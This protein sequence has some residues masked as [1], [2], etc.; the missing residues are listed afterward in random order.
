M[1]GTVTNAAGA[2]ARLGP[3]NM[4][5]LETLMLRA[6]EVVSRREL[7]ETVWRNQLISEDAL[8][9]CISDIRAELRTFSGHDEWI[10]T[11]PKRGYR[12]LAEVRELNPAEQLAYRPDDDAA[13]GPGTKRSASRWRQ[14]LVG[15]ALR[16]A[17][18]VAALAIMAVVLV[19]A[20]D[21]FAGDRAV[22]VALLPT[23]ATGELSEPAVELDLAL[24]AH[25]M[26]SNGIRVL[27]PSAIGSRPANP[28]PFFSYEFGARWL[29]EAELRKAGG[30]ITVTMT[31]ADAR[32]GIAELQVT[33]RW[34]VPA[35]AAGDPAPSAF[36]ALSQFIDAGL[37]Q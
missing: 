22:I 30:V 20:I 14:L 29:I 3:V 33:D 1:L 15:L 16:A 27:S 25:L 6:G 10:E 36:R 31:V 17:V 26:R 18:Y 13:G 4:K 32:T 12:W 21:R 11:L 19:W 5:V 7:F 35:S 37:D 23:V 34:S 8:T 24:M 2:A 28:F 9:R